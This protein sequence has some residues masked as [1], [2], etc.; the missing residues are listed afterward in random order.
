MDRRLW[1]SGWVVFHFDPREKFQG[2]SRQSTLVRRPL[3]LGDSPEVC[4]FRSR[5]PGPTDG[6]TDGRY[7]TSGLEGGVDDLGWTRR[8]VEMV[9][10]TRSTESTR[11]VTEE[12]G[13]S[14]QNVCRTRRVS[15]TQRGQ[16]IRV[17]V[18]GSDVPSPDDRSTGRKESTD[19]GLRL[20]KSEEVGEGPTSVGRRTPQLG[21]SDDSVHSGKVT[22]PQL[23]ILR[24]RLVT[25]HRPSDCP[26]EGYLSRVRTELY[27]THRPIDRHG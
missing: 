7:D 14:G 5:N 2:R 26:E 1:T 4:L 22:F 23:G 10:E 27:R 9:P 6:F 19:V 17:S 13:K 3:Y 24:L 25:L 11:G 8:L 20:G 12:R 15:E 16:R 18:D 21:V